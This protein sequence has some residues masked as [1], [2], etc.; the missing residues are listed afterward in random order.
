MLFHPSLNWDSFSVTSPF[1][2][3]YICRTKERDLLWHDFTYLDCTRITVNPLLLSSYPPL[4]SPSF[5]FTNLQHDWIHVKCV[6]TIISIL[7]VW[8]ILLEV[9]RGWHGYIFT[10]RIADSTVLGSKWVRWCLWSSLQLEP[11]LTVRT[12]WERSNS[13]R[14]LWHHS[15]AKLSSHQLSFLVLVSTLCLLSMDFPSGCRS[16]SNY[17]ANTDLVWIRCGP[18]WSFVITFNTKQL[19]LR[20]CFL[21]PFCFITCHIPVHL[22]KWWVFHFKCFPE[23]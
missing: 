17:F 16:K 5:A 8:R 21:F 9:L 10:L 22:T 3:V 14:L 11:R 1:L 12:E 15:K 19:A 23:E 18:P 20:P 6:V 4:S 13:W 7:Q 2:L